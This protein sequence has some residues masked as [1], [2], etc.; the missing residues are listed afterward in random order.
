MKLVH[1]YLPKDAGNS[2]NI[3]RRNKVRKNKHRLKMNRKEGKRRF[4]T[5]EILKKCISS[6]DFH[7][8]V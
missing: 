5:L 1:S 6:V 3:F 2:I 7:V 4:I 8:H